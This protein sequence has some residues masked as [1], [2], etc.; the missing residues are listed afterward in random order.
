MH[1]MHACTKIM[2]KCVQVQLRY[3]IIITTHSRSNYM[4][5]KL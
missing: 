3:N 1:Q 5:I 2:C 4:A